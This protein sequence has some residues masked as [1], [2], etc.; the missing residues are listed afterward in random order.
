[1]SENRTQTKVLLEVSPG[2]AAAGPAPPADPASRPAAAKLR[3]LLF[4]TPGACKVTVGVIAAAAL[5]AGVLVN[6][7]LNSAKE[8]KVKGDK[9]GGVTGISVGVEIDGTDYAR[10]SGVKVVVPEKY[11]PQRGGKKP[12]DAD[13]ASTGTPT[14]SGRPIVI[15]I[16]PKPTP[17]EPV[18]PPE[19]LKFL[20]NAAVDPE[21]SRNHKDAI[22]S[23]ELI[24]TRGFSGLPEESRDWLVRRKFAE[25]KA[26]GRALNIAW[27]AFQD[28]PFDL[29]SVRYAAYGKARFELYRYRLDQVLEKLRGGMTDVEF[30]WVGD[31]IKTTAKFLDALNREALQVTPVTLPNFVEKPNPDYVDW[32][33]KYGHLKRN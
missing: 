27:Q 17:P 28:L 32:Y 21:C 14:N 18:I 23:D 26:Y 31:Q 9:D 33:Q 3:E 29:R 19:P 2:G 15:N 22:N 16:P 6:S 12:G 11:R 1:M 24:A 8:G 30:Q 20:P 5:A 25:A 13:E 10:K 4:G 7:F